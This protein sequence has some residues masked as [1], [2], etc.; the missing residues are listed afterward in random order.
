MTVNAD[1]FDNSP[2]WL[3]HTLDNA[4]S[5]LPELQTYLPDGTLI[6]RKAVGVL[7]ITP[8]AGR[9]NPN[10]EAL[11][12]SAGVHGNETAPIEVL[13]GLVSE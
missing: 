1:L 3:S 9:A 2:D 5:D 4:R 11:I 10:S 8:P 12:V 7:D 13:N 6:I